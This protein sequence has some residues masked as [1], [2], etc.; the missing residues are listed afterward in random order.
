MHQKVI[1]QVEHQVR[2]CVASDETK[3]A[4]LQQLCILDGFENFSAAELFDW[5]HDKNNMHKEEIK[6]C[7]LV[8]KNEQI[9]YHYH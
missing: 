7:G 4:I 9:I 5:C 3:A 6:A 8:L 2:N 1:Y